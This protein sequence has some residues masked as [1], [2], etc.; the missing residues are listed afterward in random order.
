MSVT[1]L[2]HPSRRGR[3]G[4]KIFH[5][6]IEQRAD[7]GL[8]PVEIVIWQGKEDLTVKVSDQGGGVSRS[9]WDKLWHYDYSTSPLYPPVDPE[10]YPTYREQFSGGGYGLSM[11]RLFARYF[12]GDITFSSQEGVGS[13]GFI[14]AHRLGT[15]MESVV[16]LRRRMQTSALNWGVDRLA[17]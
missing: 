8:P 9:R 7:G 10:N 13:T 16:P 11:A 5:D 3:C 15:S 1:R 4:V 12:G 14:Q 6:A 2:L 17:A